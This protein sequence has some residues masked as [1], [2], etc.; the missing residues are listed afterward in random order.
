MMTSEAA[1]LAELPRLRGFLARRLGGEAADDA[2][3]E[4]MLA[5]LQGRERLRDGAQLRSWLLGI[6][7]HKAMD[8]LRRT[9]RREAWAAAYERERPRVAPS[10]EAEAL[11]EV[12]DAALLEGLAALPERER[13]ALELRAQG[14]TVGE[15]ARALGTTYKGAETCLLR[16]RRRIR[17]WM[18]ARQ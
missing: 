10:A 17:A 13:R 16:A 12:V 11:R 4:A 18:R 15:I 5:G 7:H 8:E 3:Q 9:Y 2:L 1:I 6:A 14:A